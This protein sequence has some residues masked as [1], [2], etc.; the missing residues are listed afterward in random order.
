MSNSADFF[1]NLFN[2]K[3]FNNLTIGATVA[4]SISSAAWLGSLGKPSNL[5]TGTLSIAVIASI[6]A[7]YLAFKRQKLVKQKAVMVTVENTDFVQKTGVLIGLNAEL[8]SKHLEE[9]LQHEIKP[10]TK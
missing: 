4:M 3:D 8:T 1:R 9:C 2:E 10:S 5:K 6:L 7:S